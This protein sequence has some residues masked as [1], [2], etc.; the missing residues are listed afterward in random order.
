MRYYDKI[1]MGCARRVSPAEYDL[2]GGYCSEC[3]T[4]K[5][6]VPL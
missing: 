4:G 5:R 6:T 3:M 1:C 2:Y